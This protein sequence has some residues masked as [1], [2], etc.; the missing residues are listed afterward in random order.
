[1]RENRGVWSARALLLGGEHATHHRKAAERLEEIEADVRNGGTLRL[2]A[3]LEVESTNG[4]DG[5]ALEDVEL[6]VIVELGGCFR[7]RRDSGSR[8]VHRQLDV[9]QADEAVRI[10]EGEGSEERG[11]H[12]AVDRGVRADAE[13]EN[14][15]NGEGEPGRLEE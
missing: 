13:C 12:G 2:G 15:D 1:M 14:R 3:A 4:M 6:R 11:V 7:V 10:C 5:K 8:E 9:R